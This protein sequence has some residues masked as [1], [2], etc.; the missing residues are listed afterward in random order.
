MLKVMSDIFKPGIKVFC[1]GAGGVGLSSVMQWLKELGVDVAG[2]DRE[3]SAV[4]QLLRK[5]GIQVYTEDSYNLPEK[6]DIL[7][8]SDAV[9]ESHPI[10]VECAKKGTR[11]LS[12][13]EALGVLSAGKRLIAVSGTHGKSTTTAI[14]AHMLIQ[15]G[16]DPTVV[17][18][19]LAK[20]LDGNNFRMGNS[21]I[22]VVEADEYRNHFLFLKPHIAV[23]TNVDYDHVDSFP[24]RSDYVDAFKKFI[25]NVQEGGTVVARTSDD[26]FKVISGRNNITTV[27]F[28]LRSSSNNN[29][30]LTLSIIRYSNGKQFFS[31]ESPKYNAEFSIPFTGNHFVL[32]AGAAL[33]VAS[34]LGVSESV[35]QDALSTFSGTWRR[36]EKVGLFNGIPVISDYAHH[37][38]EIDALLGGAR[39]AYPD[40]KLFVIFQPHQGVRTITFE[41]D[42]LQSLSKAD[43]VIVMEL[44]G[45]AGR[46]G[47]DPISTRGWIQELLAKG[48][49]AFFAESLEAA[50]NIVRSHDLSGR[51]ILVV[52]AGSI[53]RLARKLVNNDN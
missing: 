9:Q 48:V 33:A 45:V 17:I 35:A 36:F 16:L 19:T 53:D 31:V 41:Q 32:D 12:Y 15:A 10:R 8:Y 51:V 14:I 27:G 34:V 5:K 28:D 52:G 44:Y 23:I 11:Q 30:N 43:E 25:D 1:V 4:V 7:I 13:A 38:A 18:G 37:P 40:R 20:D 26:F 29:A 3:E 49:D 46:E 39:Q 50:E 47:K 24:N 42:F 22:V 21:D 6:T 2:S